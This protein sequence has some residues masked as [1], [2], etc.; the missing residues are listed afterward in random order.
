MLRAAVLVTWATDTSECYQ[1][2]GRQAG[3]QAEWQKLSL[4]AVGGLGVSGSVSFLLDLMG[5]VYLLLG[6]YLCLV[7]R[8]HT[9]TLFSSPHGALHVGLFVLKL[10]PLCKV[11]W[12]S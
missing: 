8:Y 6:E 10:F 7:A 11:H 5:A 4:P 2:A 12:S 9:P 1:Q 3:M